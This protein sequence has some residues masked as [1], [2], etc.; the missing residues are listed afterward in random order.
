MSNSA[1]HRAFSQS[2]ASMT[3]RDIQQRLRAHLF[4]TEAER[5][6]LETEAVRNEARR[7][8]RLVALKGLKFSKEGKFTEARKAATEAAALVKEWRKLGGKGPLT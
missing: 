4:G 1:C 5:R 2:A 7:L 8:A 6:R 3:I